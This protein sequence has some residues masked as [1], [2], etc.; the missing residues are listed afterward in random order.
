[1]DG[2]SGVIGFGGTYCGAGVGAGGLVWAGIIGFGGIYCGAGFCTGGL[3]WAGAIG[4]G[5]AA[6]FGAAGFLFPI[7]TPIITPINIHRTIIK[8]R[9][10]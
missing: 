10:I 8:K 4:F 5:G 3:A 6:G 1:M 2:A 9:V 7:F